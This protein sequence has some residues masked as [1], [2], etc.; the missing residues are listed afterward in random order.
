MACYETGV[1]DIGS[2]LIDSGSLG[3]RNITPPCRI[4]GMIFGRRCSSLPTSSHDLRKVTLDPVNHHC[5]V[6]CGLMI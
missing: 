3:M 4:S 1:M 2:T 5:Q 6:Q